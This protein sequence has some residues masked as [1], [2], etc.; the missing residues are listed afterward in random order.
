[1][2]DLGASPPLVVSP[3]KDLL[4]FRCSSTTLTLPVPMRNQSGYFSDCTTSIATKF[5]R[6]I[7]QLLGSESCG[8]EATHPVNFK[9]CVDPKYL[10][11]AIALGIF[12][13]AGYDSFFDAD[14][15]TYLEAQ[16]QESRKSINLETLDHIVDTELRMEISDRNAK[17]RVENL[18]VA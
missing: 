9:F 2:F 16:A 12:A 1:M 10:E 14:L 11:S 6:L 18:F 3:T 8:T 17:S 15:R 5:K 7:T 4:W 13:A